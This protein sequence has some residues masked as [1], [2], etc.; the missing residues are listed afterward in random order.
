MGRPK[1]SKNKVP[2]PPPV[3]PTFK[4]MTCGKVYEDQMKYFPAS[5]SPLYKGNNNRLPTCIKCLNRF[6]EEYYKETGSDKK[7]MRKLCSKFDIYWNDR[8]FEKAGA[9]PASNDFIKAYIATTCLNPNTNKTYSNTLEE[10]EMAG[11]ISEETLAEQARKADLLSPEVYDRWGQGYSVDELRFAE[12]KYNTL[13]DQTGRDV[14]ETE[15][16]LLRDLVNAEILKNRAM[17]K[18]DVEEYSKCSKMYRDILK[19]TEFKNRKNPTKTTEVETWGK[20]IQE[21]EQYCPADLYKRPSL[22]EDTDKI[23]EYFQRFIVRPVV[24]FFTG[25]RDMD[26]EYSIDSGDT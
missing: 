25:Q 7:A 9:N 18:G 6:L 26:E 8:V 17:R 14:D 12:D 11:I 22:F 19:E 10:D 13:L 21:I 3:K 5:H 23:G 20:F 16:S 15:N 1:G 24:N 4:C 2:A